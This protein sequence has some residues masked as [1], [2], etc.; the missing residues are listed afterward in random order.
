MCCVCDSIGGPDNVSTILPSV[1]SPRQSVGILSHGRTAS[2]V[3]PSNI[4][5]SDPAFHPR[6][7]CLHS[8]YRSPPASHSVSFSRDLKS[9]GGA[10]DHGDGSRGSAA[11]YKRQCMSVGD[12]IDERVEL[13]NIDYLSVHSLAGAK[14]PVAALESC[15]G[16]SDIVA[17]VAA[18]TPRSVHCPPVRLPVTGCTS[19]D[20]LPTSDSLALPH[21][22]EVAGERGYICC[23]SAGKSA[24]IEVMST[25]KPSADAA[26]DASLD[27]N[28][29]SLS[30]S[31]G[32]ARCCGAN[33]ADPRAVCS[34]HRTSELTLL[35]ITN[36]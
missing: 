17:M 29:C 12:S 27:K 19:I 2:D 16:G 24:S 20:I 21:I 5:T 8:S 4:N 1:V 3:V 6:V 15:A 11:A 25:A 35:D 23:P 9:V 7:S 36:L 22:P 34:L 26:A 14:Q 30:S 28:N 10:G 13:V 32:D 18:S 33:A 31:A